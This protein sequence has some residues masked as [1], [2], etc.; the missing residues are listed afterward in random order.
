MSAS[1][2]IWKPLLEAVEEALLAGG[3]LEF[4]DA[5]RLTGMPPESLGALTQAADRVRRHFAR[6]RVD[7]CSIVNARSGACGEDCRFC[8][9][10]NRYGTAAPVYPMK[11]ADDILEAARGAE[12]AGAHRF[13]IVTS[14]GTLSNQDFEQVLEAVI[15]IR[16][17]TGL[18][19]CASTGT[20]NRERA[21]LLKEAGL[22]RYHHNVETARSYFPEICSTHSYMHKLR[23]IAHL[24]EAGIE[25]CTGGILNLGES[26]RQRIE[27]AYE[28]RDLAPDSIPIN[29]LIPVDG[30]PLAGREALAANEAARYLAIFRLVMPGASLRVAGGRL[31][32]FAGRLELPFNAGANALLIGNLLTTA[33]PDARTDISLLECLGFNTSASGAVHR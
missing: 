17:E 22:D 16:E 27:M 32:T 7:I 29:F 31:E 19:R 5:L 15:R 18:R 33:G 20:I 2:D 4:D 9:Q 30:T 12:A 21:A 28:I 25:V 26:P 11:S 3:S 23:T 14:G 1:V 10:S 8:A 6:E 24:K 13:C